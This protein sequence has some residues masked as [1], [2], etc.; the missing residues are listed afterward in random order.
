MRMSAIVLQ[1]PAS[2]IQCVVGINLYRWV[3]FAGAALQFVARIQLDGVNIAPGNVRTVID[4]N[5]LNQVEMQIVNAGNSVAPIMSLPTSVGG[6]P[7]F[8]I[9]VAAGA[10]ITFGAVSGTNVQI[11]DHNIV[12]GPGRV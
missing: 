5:N 4:R 3:E 12:Q 11:G 8:H 2:T 7:I 6:Q 1:G 10:S 9:E